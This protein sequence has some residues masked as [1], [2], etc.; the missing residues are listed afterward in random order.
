MKTSLPPSTKADDWTVV[1]TGWDPEK[2]THHGNLF[3][4]GNGCMGCRGTL[5]EFGPDEKVGILLPGV[6][7]RVGDAWREPV[8]AP[9][10]LFARLAV[11]GRWLTP[12]EI[13]PDSHEQCLD[14]RTASSFILLFSS[15]AILP[16]P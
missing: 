9:N 11:N 3:L 5:E 16:I 13:Q 14:M 2:V 7:D 6:Y 4:L 15:L 10:G 1:A 8:N 12:F